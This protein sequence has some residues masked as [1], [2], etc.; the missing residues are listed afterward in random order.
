VRRRGRAVVRRREEGVMNVRVRRSAPL[1]A[2]VEEGVV[3]EG[4]A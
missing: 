1:L 2:A 4:E 3:E